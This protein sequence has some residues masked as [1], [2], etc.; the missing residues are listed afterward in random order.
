MTA[1]ALKAYIVVATK[2]RPDDV[3]ILHDCLLTQTVQPEH[4]IFVGTE[5]DDFGAAHPAHEGQITTF[6]ICDRP[7]LTSQRNIGLDY[8]LDK[9]GPEN[10]FIIIYFDDDFRPH[11]DWVEKALIC[12]TEHDIVGLTGEVLADGINSWGISEE[13]AQKY[14]KGELSPMS[15]W[16]ARYHNKEPESAY[17]CNMA[18]SALVS[19]ALRFDEMLPAYGWLED[20]DYSLFSKRLGSLRCDTACKGV[21]LGTKRGRVSGVKFGYS[22]IANPLY[23][24]KKGSLP[25]TD[26]ISFVLTNMGA[27]HVKSLFPESWVDRRGRV[28]GNWI[29][30]FD[31]IKGC[32][33]PLR[34][35]DF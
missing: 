23:L 21:H 4:I 28:K 6:L 34:I 12:F 32:L 14:L 16:T 10:N 3:A 19:R 18:Y 20:K 33:S 26:A 1:A 2:G 30:I 17:G 27:N 13:H 9:Q 31:L 25:F 5:Q 15:H 24:S 29:A 8:I 7:G 11:K 22:Q 35:N